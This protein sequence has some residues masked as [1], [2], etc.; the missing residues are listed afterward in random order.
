M[1]RSTRTSAPSPSTDAPDMA[2][3]I[4][5]AVAQG[6]AQAL[7]TIGS[8]EGNASEPQ[9]EPTPAPKRKRASSPAKPTPKA[10]SARKGKR[11]PRAKVSE[12]TVRESWAGQEASPRMIGRAI[13][14]GLAPTKVAKMDKLALSCALGAKYG[15]PIK[16]TP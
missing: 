2:Q 12:W 14:E 13:K 7:A 6:V 5:A 1:A 8:A 15:L 4:A 10:S 3:I 16:R 11:E 9:A